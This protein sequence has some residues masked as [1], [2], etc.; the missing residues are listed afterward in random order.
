M[1]AEHQ[2]ACTAPP[3]IDVAVREYPN[4]AALLCAAANQAMHMAEQPAAEPLAPAA[5]AAVAMA[6][7]AS[8]PRVLLRE[9]R[10]VECRRP[11]SG[12]HRP[13]GLAP[14]SSLSAR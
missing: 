11:S 14:P 8:T 7:C 6:T 10:V 9:L 3:A 2:S 1:A 12:A 13:L 5:A 4:I